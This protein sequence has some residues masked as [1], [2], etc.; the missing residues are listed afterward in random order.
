MEQVAAK[1]ITKMMYQRPS[2][3]LHLGN[4][5]LNQIHDS[6]LATGESSFRVRMVGV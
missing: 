3:D 5:H 4:N 2:P 6:N 1:E